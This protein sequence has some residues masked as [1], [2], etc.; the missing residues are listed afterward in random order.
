MHG[1]QEGRI[2]PFIDVPESIHDTQRLKIEHFIEPR[3]KNKRGNQS[4]H[5]NSSVLGPIE[6]DK[7]I[8]NL[9]KQSG[10]EVANYSDSTS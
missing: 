8:Q 5:K 6:E 2:K 9:T 10:R 3:K 4:I 7:D 1:K